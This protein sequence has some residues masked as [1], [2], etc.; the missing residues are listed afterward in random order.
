[1][2]NNNL[3]MM[4][5]LLQTEFMNQCM[6]NRYVMCIHNLEVCCFTQ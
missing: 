3:N 6:Y 1:M 5:D 2:M 4:Y